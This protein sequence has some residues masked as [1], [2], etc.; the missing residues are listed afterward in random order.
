LRQRSFLGGEQDA[1]AEEGQS[2]A[3]E[4]LAFDHLDVVDASFDGAGVPAGGQALGDGVEVL[5]QA[6]G[7]GGDARQAGSASVRD[8]WSSPRR[9]VPAGSTP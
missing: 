8:P 6:L 3:S 7:E 9:S 4:H 1:L 2:G 5:L